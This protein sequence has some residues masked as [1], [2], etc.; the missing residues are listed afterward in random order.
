MQHYLEMTFTEFK[1]VFEKQ[2]KELSDNG[3]LTFSLDIS[4]RLLQDYRIFHEKYKW[5]NPDSLANGIKYCELV[6]NG[7]KADNYRIEE[8]MSAIDE[9]TPN[10]DDFGDWDGSYALN[11]CVAVIESL[12]FLLDKNIE[13]IVNVSSCMTDTVDFKIT[14]TFGDLSEDAIDAH[15]WM[16][17]E[18][19]EQIT[20]TQ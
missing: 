18:R 5:G 8:L 11:A 2:I 10:T 12:E 7:D 4:K 16:I 3:R 19:N 1:N 9:V 13:H 17:S 14:E 20:M 6:L 15:P